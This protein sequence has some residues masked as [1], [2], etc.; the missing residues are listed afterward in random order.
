MREEFG[1]IP[2]TVMEQLDT[3]KIDNVRRQIGCRVF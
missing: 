1:F 3:E 2:K